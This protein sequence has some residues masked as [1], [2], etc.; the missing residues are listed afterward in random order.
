MRN[1][2]VSRILRILHHLELNANGLAAR[3][4]LNKLN[5]EGHNCSRE[6]VYR[7]LKA[8]EQAFIPLDIDESTD[9]SKY[10]LSRVAHVSKDVAFSYVEL[11][12]LTI[13]RESMRIFDGTTLE[14]VLNPMFQRL[15]K[16]LGLK[17]EKAMKEF[18]EYMGF[19]HRASYGVKVPREILDTLHQACAEGHVLDIDYLAS[20]GERAGQV[21]TRKV[22][23]EMLYFA[24]SGIYLI[25]RDLATESQ[26]MKTYAVAR[27]KRAMMSD[28]E[29]TSKGFDFDHFQKDSLAVYR[30]GEIAKVEINIK[31]PMASYIAE[32]QWHPSQ[33]S[34]RTASGIRLS[35]E[36]RVN[37][38]LVRWILG[39]GSSA[40][41]AS[42]Q[43][44][45]EQMATEIE[46]L[47]NSYTK[48][49]S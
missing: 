20:S 28:E 1:R 13:S 40:E 6:T 44:L 38:E 48:K 29:Y 10:K 46:R 34:V 24:D 30:E 37:D 35:L 33:R 16:L 31:E 23:P 45:R 9:P 49:A 41:V 39:M 3:D 15:E 2:Q 26:Q 11:L 22:G 5:D 21:A 17:G 32:R 43:K 36:V 27:V 8:I 4:I 42:P 18:S 19:K 47:S 12:A 25:A 7:D 14:D